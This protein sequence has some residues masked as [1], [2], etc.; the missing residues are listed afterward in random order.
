MVTAELAVALLAV[1][2]LLIPLCWGIFVLVLQARCVGTAAEVARQAARA[3]D[4][5]LQRARDAAP[6]GAVVTV[7]RSGE[8]TTVHVRL[9]ARPP[10][11]GLPA[12]PL[13]ASAAVVTEPGVR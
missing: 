12:V 8:V 10:L 13:Q 9:D 1:L 5:A 6:E 2:S 4:A 3:D 7:S 11:R